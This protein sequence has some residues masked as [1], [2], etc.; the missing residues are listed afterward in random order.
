MARY[1]NVEAP[2]YR[3]VSKRVYESSHHFKYGM[4]Y[5]PAFSSTSHDPNVAK[6]FSQRAKSWDPT[7]ESYKYAMYLADLDNYE[8]LGDYHP[9]IDT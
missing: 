4:N 8:Q 3:G 9:N 1:K 7:K 5:F 2:V 6:K